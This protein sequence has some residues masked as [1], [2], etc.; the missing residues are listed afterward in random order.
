MAVLASIGNA[1]K[2]GWERSGK[3]KNAVDE[4]SGNFK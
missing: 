1:F 4:Y 3:N 2:Q